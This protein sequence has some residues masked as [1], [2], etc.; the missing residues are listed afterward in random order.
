M[1]R[2]RPCARGFIQRKTSRPSWK[3]ELLPA[4]NHDS[5]KLSNRKHGG[6]N[7]DPAMKKVAH[8]DAKGGFPASVV[9][10][11]SLKPRPSLGSSQALLLLLSCP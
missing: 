1:K 6:R 3:I 5:G 11:T 8:I 10:C 7:G 9:A 4:L 2:G